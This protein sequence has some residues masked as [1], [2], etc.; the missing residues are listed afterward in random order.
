MPSYNSALE[1]IKS[2]L[3][4]VDVISEY[5]PL[6]KA[7][8]NWKGICPFHTEKTPSFMVSQAK[9]IYHCF[10]C[11]SGGDI[12]TFLVK[13]ENLSFN[14]SLNILA[15]KAG[16]TLQKF[17]KDTGS[18][19]E[20]ENLLNI[21]RDACIFFQESLKQNVK[22]KNYLK[23]RGISA[24][25]QK[26]FSLGFAPH[27]WDRLFS[28]LKDKN[29]NV[30]I[31][32]KS[33]L[34]T[35][36]AKGY[37]DTFRDRIIFPIFNALGE[38]IAFGGRVMDDSLPKYLN[39]PESPIF[40][41]SRVLYGLN[42]AKDPIKKTGFAMFVEGYLDVITAHMYEF[43]NTVAPL[44]T[45]LTKEHGKLIKRFTDE[46]VLVF[47]GDAA[48]VK[49]AKNG[50]GIL[51]ESGLHVRALPLPEGEDPDSILRKEGRDVFV[52]AADK[53]L[54]LVDFFAVQKKDK[55][56]IAHEI[57]ET[58]FKIPDSILLGYYVKLL[59][60]RLK[61]NEIFVREEL[62]KMRKGH[63]I[64]ELRMGRTNVQR[65]AEEHKESPHVRPISRPMDEIYILQLIIQ[66][67]GMADVVFES[68][69]A[70]DFEDAVTKSIFKKMKDG[71]IDYDILVAQCVEE[72]K[73]LLTELL[74]ATG[75][76][77]PEKIL[78]DCRKRL[79][80]KKRNI[81]LS[82]F[83]DKIRKAEAEKNDRLLRSLLQEKQKLISSEE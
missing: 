7:G 45:A 75:L 82:E 32:K 64:R 6:K 19:S 62:K 78:K 3:D 48:G 4:I 35:H 11:G 18:V 13:Y 50:I 56:L 54:S 53:A 41:K 68:I 22:A 79:K 25:A 23:E 74:L 15:K 80:S 14:E 57:L 10:G 33:G 60:E 43:S 27:A 63:Q 47:D 44:G 83:Q 37:Y 61:I 29:Y 69:S 70:E 9:Q 66:F 49:A 42:L 21:H 38:V 39:S 52:T 20:K 8:Q 71:F 17:Q 76:E 51:L 73:N 24:E 34:V 16:V 1:E 72:E 81:L 31:I 46:A 30:E 59:S 55:R 12:F 77:N 67:P 58:I 36:G 5:V 28:Y 65:L 40:S 2:R 26:I